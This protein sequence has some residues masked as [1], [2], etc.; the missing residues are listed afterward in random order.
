MEMSFNSSERNVILACLYTYEKQMQQALKGQ[1]SDS[2]RNSSIANE[3]KT[4]AQIKEK[5]SQGMLA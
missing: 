5:L 4:I 3:L 1:N 2:P